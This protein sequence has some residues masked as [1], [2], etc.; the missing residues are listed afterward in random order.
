[1]LASRSSF[2][3]DLSMSES[4]FD[5]LSI[6]PLKAGAGNGKPLL[7][8]ASSSTLSLTESTSLLSSPIRVT[9]SVTTPS[10]R[11][12]AVD[13]DDSLG[14]VACGSHMKRRR[15][16]GQPRPE[17]ADGGKEA[18]DSPSGDVPLSPSAPLSPLPSK[19]GKPGE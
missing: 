4:L 13:D 6:T 1:M 7:A 19:L 14:L 10:R 8:S 12:I 3:N 16:R 11:A 18:G 2:G 15:R 17:G 5:V 9:D